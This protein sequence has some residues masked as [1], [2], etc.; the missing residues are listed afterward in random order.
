VPGE[1]RD[2]QAIPAMTGSVPA[3][4]SGPGAK[5]PSRRAESRETAK[6]M[7]VMG[8]NATPA[9]SGLKPR[10]SCRNWVRKKNI[11]NMPATRNILAR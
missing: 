9:R 7:T 4:V 3:T 2:S 6:T 10:M 8:R 1:I 11:P 5:R